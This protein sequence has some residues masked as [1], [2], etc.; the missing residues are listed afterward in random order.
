[1]TAERSR[2]TPLPDGS[3]VEVDVAGV[4]IVEGR[5]ECCEELVRLGQQMTAERTAGRPGPRVAVAADGARPGTY[6]SPD[7]S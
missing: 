3:D 5:F 7:T 1:M 4:Q 6:L 2:S